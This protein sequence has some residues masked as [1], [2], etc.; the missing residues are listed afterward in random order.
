MPTEPQCYEGVVE[1]PVLARKAAGD[2]LAMR[3]SRSCYR[4]DGVRGTP[5]RPDDSIP[6]G[7]AAQRAVAKC[8]VW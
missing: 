4:R 5:S 1:G 6:E 2:A 3:F 8:V 7:G